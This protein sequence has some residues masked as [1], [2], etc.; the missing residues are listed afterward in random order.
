RGA[1]PGPGARATDPRG[2]PVLDVRD[3]AVAVQR[4]AL[5]LAAL[6]RVALARTG[7]RAP[8]LKDAGGGARAREPD[9][10]LRRTVEAHG[11]IR[12]RRPRGR[13]GARRARRARGTLVPAVRVGRTLGGRTVPRVPDAAA[14][15]R[16]GRPRQACRARP[17]AR[18]DPARRRPRTRQRR[19][20]RQR[21]RA[22]QRPR[23]RRRRRRAADPG[24]AG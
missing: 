9:P 4:G 18:A 17:R 14:A 22:R 13:R 12:R 20:T 15:G 6:D 7:G 19:R 3:E 21:P 16:T 2:P 1:S 8:V 5:L 23:T 10:P 11:T 24:P